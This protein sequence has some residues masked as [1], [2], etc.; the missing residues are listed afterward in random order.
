MSVLKNAADA[1]LSY[2]L[3][4]RL[5]ASNSG[6]LLLS[7]PNALGQGAFDALNAPGAE[8]PLSDTTG[9]YNA[10]ISVMRPEEIETIPGGLGAISERGHEFSYTLGPVREVVPSGWG[11]VSK[12]WFIQVRSP[13]LEKLRKSYGLSAKPKNNEFDFHI[14]FAIQKKHVL[15]PNSITKTSA[16]DLLPGGKADGQP[17]SAFPDKIL[18]E[19]AEHEGEHTKNKQLAREI[20]KDHLVEDEKYYEKLEQIEKPASALFAGSKLAQQIAAQDDSLELDD[21]VMDESE[22]PQQT[23]FDVNPN[24]FSNP[25]NVHRLEPKLQPLYN[26]W[27]A[28][29]SPRNTGQLLQNLQPAIDRG[30]AAHLGA[31][32]NDPIM[33]SRAR[34]LVLKALP[35]Y[36]PSRSQLGTFITSQLRGLKREAAKQGRILSMPERVAMERGA[37]L[38]AEAE[39]EDANGRSPSVQELADKTGLSVRRITYV[40]KFRS[41]VAEGTIEAAN[42]GTENEAPQIAVR[43]HSDPWAD[44]VYDSLDNTN[45]RIFEWTSGYGGAPKLSG[46]EIAKKLRLTPG[47][48]SQR[49]ARIQK[50]YDQGADLNPF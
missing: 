48:V 35:R 41:P 21:N 9:R 8:M 4:G 31:N 20:A 18:D 16:E 45:K 22:E 26:T 7:V 13:D 14:T 15:K 47:A 34:Q 39:F 2:G 19:G 25:Q 17:D 44:V 27:K 46:E 3:R 10:H 36:D 1:E 42:E 12:C 40:R 37:L 50:I 43:G 30:M 33:R 23:L 6:W 24:P 49:K 28:E 5:Q 32:T 29:P 38:G 11:D